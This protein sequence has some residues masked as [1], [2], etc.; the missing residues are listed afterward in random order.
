MPAGHCTFR[1]STGCGI[2]AKIGCCRSPR[3]L[4]RPVSNGSVP[5]RLDAVITDH[6]GVAARRCSGCRPGH[7]AVHAVPAAGARA[8]AEQARPRCPEARHRQ[9]WQKCCSCCASSCN[10][11]SAARACVR[12]NSCACASLRP[13]EGAGQASQLARQACRAAFGLG[14][15][16]GS[17]RLQLRQLRL[18]SSLSCTCSA[19]AASGSGDRRNARRRC[20]TR[21]RAA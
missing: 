20:S 16:L 10:F 14:R 6:S 3:T 1:G 17:L 15:G 11:G 5:H 21:C 19:S 18:C 4:G 7:G 9:R 8:A 2:A 12:R 13:V